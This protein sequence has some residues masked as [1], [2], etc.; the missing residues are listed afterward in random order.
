[1][2]RRAHR[3]RDA[4]VGPGGD[5]PGERLDPPHL[6]AGQRASQSVP[7]SRRRSAPE[8]LR[9]RSSRSF[10]RFTD[11]ARRYRRRGRPWFDTRRGAP[12]I[13]PASRKRSPV[14]AP[15]FEARQA[16]RCCARS[17]ARSSTP[18]PSRRR[19]TTRS[20][21]LQRAGYK[22]LQLSID[23]E[24]SPGYR[25]APPAAHARHP[26]GCELSASTADDLRFLRRSASTRRAPGALA[27]RQAEDARALDSANRDARSAAARLA[28]EALAPVVD[29]PFRAAQIY[30]ALYRRGVPSF[31]AMTDLAKPMRAR[32]AERFRSACRRSSSAD[33]AATAP[34][35]TCSASPTAPRSRRST[36]RTATAAPV[37]LEPGRLRARL[38][39]LRHRLLGRRAQPDRRRD[40][41][42]GAGLRRPRRCPEGLNLVFMGMGE[43]L[44]NLDACATRSDMLD[45]VDLA[46]AHHR[47]DRRASCPGIEEI[48]A[49][50]AAAEPGDLAARA[51]RRAPRPQ[52]MPVN[53][54]WPLA[55]LLA[56]LRRYPLERGR[57]SPSSTS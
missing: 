5:V 6:A 48:G 16:R 1:M 24:P 4:E 33:S 9:E 39:L 49:L 43:P 40:R 56:A 52:I 10:G 54:T 41:R 53:R 22:S 23:C 44:L 46:A 35:S 14:D 51:G 30:D 20:T 3:E 2:A 32:L 55:E 28:R 17:S 13:R 36:S 50:A 8:T 25:A 21:Q 31:E 38:R 26:R 19:F 47:L 42:P 11:I 7:R 18:S 37:H 12:I 29:R 57:R 15:R 45:R 27:P 34:P